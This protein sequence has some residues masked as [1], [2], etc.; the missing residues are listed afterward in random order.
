MSK[1]VRSAGHRIVLKRATRQSTAEAHEALFTGE[2][3]ADVPAKSLVELKQGL[4]QAIR[5]RRPRPGAG[6]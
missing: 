4:R 5:R 6:R 2:Q 3:P 1:N